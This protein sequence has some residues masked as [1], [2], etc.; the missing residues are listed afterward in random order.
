MKSKVIMLLLLSGALLTNALSA[1]GTASYSLRE[2]VTFAIQ[3]NSEI[4]ESIATANTGLADLNKARANLYPKISL[5]SI[6]AP[7]YKVE[8]NALNYNTDYGK[9]GYYLNNKASLIQPLYTFGKLKN[10]NRAAELGVQIKKMDVRNKT[11]EVAYNVKKYY[12][13]LQ[14]AKKMDEMLSEADRMLSDVISMIKS[15]IK[16]SDPNVSKADLYKLQSYYEMLKV[17]QADAQAGVLLAQKTLKLYMG[18]NINKNVI[19]TETEL[20]LYDKDFMDLPYYMG[21]MTAHRP[22]IHKLNMGIKALEY[23]LRATEKENYPDFFIGAEL[24]ANHSNATEDQKNPWLND[25]YNYLHG[26]VGIGMKWGI[27]LKPD[28]SGELEQKYNL[29]ALKSKKKY[30]VNGIEMLVFKN[31]Q[32]CITGKNKIK[33]LKRM[34]KITKKWGLLAKVNYEMGIG[35]AKD[36]LEALAMYFQASKDYYEQIY[37]FNIAKAALEKESGIILIK[38]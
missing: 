37:K 15:K 20:R 18:L 36:L 14:Y 25:E 2:A 17:Q 26:G 21:Y 19:F 1:Q 22:D 24:E 3:H 10:Y 11:N 6:A 31:Y 13:S 5:T 4:Q 8:G 32:D 7:M 16:N 35:E 38:K 27:N 33:H 23:M 9:W 34:L 12:F 28:K 29:A 30:A